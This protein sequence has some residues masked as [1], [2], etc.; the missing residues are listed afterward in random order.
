MAE[1]NPGRGAAQ[2][3]DAAAE[4]CETSERP[5]ERLILQRASDDLYVGRVWVV[6]D[7]EYESLAVRFGAGDDT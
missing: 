5:V 1:A 2:I 3:L 4:Q 6:G 7:D